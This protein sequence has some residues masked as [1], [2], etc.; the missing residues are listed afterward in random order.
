MSAASLSDAGLRR[1]ASELFGSES[2]DALLSTSLQGER[3]Q[4]WDDIIQWK[5][6]EWVVFPERFDGDDIE[7]PTEESLRAATREAMEMRD[8]EEPMPL[9]DW[10][11]PTGDG[12]I[13]FRWGNPAEVLWTL[14]FTADGQTIFETIEQCHTTSSHVVRDA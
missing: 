12:G 13:A 14:E 8:D 10:V 5:L 6:L 9:P 2:G 3:R 4:G 1:Y 7:P 11:V